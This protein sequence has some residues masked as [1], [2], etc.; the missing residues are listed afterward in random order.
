MA[1]TGQH[2]TVAPRIAIIIGDAGVP[3]AF[4]SISGHEPDLTLARREAAS[5]DQATQAMLPLATRRGAYVSEG[6]CFAVARQQSYSGANWPR[7][8]AVKKRYDPGGLSFVQ[9]GV[10]SEE[11]GVD[12]VTQNR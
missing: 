3:P 10:G 6:N 12:G 7:L 8:R 2:R 5:I 9:H 1:A 11:C 4:S